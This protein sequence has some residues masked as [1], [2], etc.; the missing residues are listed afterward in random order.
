[1]SSPPSP[2]T[3]DDLPDGGGP[4]P[5]GRHRL[6][7]E[8]VRASQRGRLLNA[9]LWTAAHKGYP[10]MTI[11]DLVERASVSRRTFYE[12]FSG[13]VE[14]FLAAIDHGVADVVKAIG[15]AETAVSGQ[16]WR[17]RLRSGIRAYLKVLAS[18]P[19]ASWAVHI[20]TL[21][22]GGDMV[23]KVMQGRDQFALLFRATH[24]YARAQGTPVADVDDA[25]LDV[26]IGGIADAIRTCLR[27]RGAA[28]LPQLEDSFVEA[29]L[30]VFGVP[31]K[32][33]PQP[34]DDGVTKTDA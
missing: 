6:D 14:C 30:R 15:A 17:V 29:T 26:L 27:Q 11:G 28:A 31:T 34:G 18:A 32:N 20:E 2:P 16:D 19:E 10:E 1:M 13:K 9:A 23:D 33:P 3:F 25:V 4:L 7:P 5:S 22:A 12:H 24:A 21:R 8:Q